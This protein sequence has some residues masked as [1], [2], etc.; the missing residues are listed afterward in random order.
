MQNLRVLQ[1]PPRLGHSTPNKTKI[2]AQMKDSNKQ[3]ACPLGWAISI[4][5]WHWEISTT[6]LT[7]WPLFFQRRQRKPAES[8]NS[9][10]LKRTVS[11]R[12]G[13][14]KKC[15][16]PNGRNKMIYPVYPCINGLCFNW[17]IPNLYMEI[18]CLTNSIHLKLVV[19]SCKLWI[20]WLPHV[21]SWLFEGWKSILPT[22][23][24]FGNFENHIPVRI[25]TP[26]L[27]TPDPPVQGLK[28]G[29]FL[30][31]KMT[32]QGFLG[33]KGRTTPS[34]LW[35]CMIFVSLEWINTHL[36]YGLV[37]SPPCEPTRD[38]VHWSMGDLY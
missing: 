37:L 5:G 8:G 1:K 28:Q 21:Q 14:K 12:C 17:M 22:T 10:G 30:T 13:V 38:L 3:P 32:S 20:V 34:S 16:I 23:F 9:N 26:P 2:A 4:G 36:A 35:S 27:E 29:P 6:F 19:W 31:P 24:L 7:V 15:W 33:S 11:Q 25:L 18:C